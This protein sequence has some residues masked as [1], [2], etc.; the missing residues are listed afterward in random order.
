MLLSYF[1]VVAA[2]AVDNQLMGQEV[3]YTATKVPDR[4]NITFNGNPATSFAVNW[5]SDSTMILPMVEM[6][7][8][9]DSST[10]RPEL[11]MP[12]RSSSKA[13]TEI[14]VMGGFKTLHH[15]HT[16]SDLEP[17]TL[18][19]FRV[20]QEKYW[21]EWFHYRTASDQNESFSFIYLGDAQNNIKSMWSRTIRQAFS[22]QPNASFI[23]H[24]G[25]LINRR[26]EWE[27]DEWFYA[28]SFIHSMIPVVPVTGNHEHPKTQEGKR[29]LMPNWI[30]Q[31]TLPENGPKNSQET[32][33]YVD[34]QGARIVILNSSLF[35][36]N[37]GYRKEQ[38]EW[39]HEI[40]SSNPNKWTLISYHHPM[41]K[42]VLVEELKPILEKYDVD[43]AM[44]GHVHSYSRGITWNGADYKG[45]PMY[46]VSVSGPKFYDLNELNG[47]DMMRSGHHKQLYQIININRDELTYQAYTTTGKLYDEFKIIKKKNQ[48]KFI[49]NL[50]SK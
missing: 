44:Q 23:L 21:S 26:H 4:I 19:A 35:Q 10:A 8:A 46:T 32:D 2:A 16:F 48:K 41:S 13:S 18:Y 36:D 45:G 14:L 31:F 37:D 30:Q 3:L 9:S 42:G 49:N 47:F 24:A 1:L 15:S 6:A 20:G 40:L 25:D 34:Y 50:K 12:F 27:W 7:L 28:G 11:E 39:L 17:E 5:R 29:V 43:L 22:D 33:Y 38:I